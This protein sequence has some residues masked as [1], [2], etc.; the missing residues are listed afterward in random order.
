ADAWVVHTFEIPV[1]IVGWHDA[2]T[3][4]LEACVEE[5]A[6][7]A[8]AKTWFERRLRERGLEMPLLEPSVSVRVDDPRRATLIATVP[9]LARRRAAI[10][11][12]VLRRF[13]TKRAAQLSTT[14]NAA[15]TTAPTP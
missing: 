15:P 7:A 13:L 5:H 12:A 11:Q 4:L 2:E 3:A 6:Q 10:E 14:T 8:E 9:T 1:D